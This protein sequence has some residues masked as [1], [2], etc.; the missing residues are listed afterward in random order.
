LADGDYDG[1]VDE[2][3][4]GDYDQMEAARVVA[5][6]AACIRHTAR[7]RPKMSQVVKALQ[8]E[9]PLETLND[10][11]RGATL[12]SVSSMPGPEYGQSG[13]SSYTVQMERIRKVALPSPEYSTEYAGPISGFGHPSPS[14]GSSVDSNVSPA[15]EHV[16]VTNQRHR[17]YRQV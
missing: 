4:D 13:T 2:R 7:R 8:G 16:P 11:A 5:C 9:V 10:A 14:P 12:S 6:A 3:L 1:L 17:G 15:G